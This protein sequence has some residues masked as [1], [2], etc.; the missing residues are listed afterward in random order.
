[1]AK[2]KAPA[3]PDVHVLRGLMEE[4]QE[5]LRRV[6]RG[7]KKALSLNP[8]REQFWD[9]LADVAPEISMVEARSNTIWEEIIHLVDQLPE[10]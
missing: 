7:V 5:M 1:M 8:Q 9:A 6:D 2:A 3:V 4:Y 10:D